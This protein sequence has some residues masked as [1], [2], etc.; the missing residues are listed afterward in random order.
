MTQK[1][2]S[3]VARFIDTI[4]IVINN[5]VNILMIANYAYR[6]FQIWS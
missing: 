2:I 3:A 1:M 6:V 4:M 5:F